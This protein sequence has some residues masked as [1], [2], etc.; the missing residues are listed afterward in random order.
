MKTKTTTKGGAEQYL[1]PASEVVLL[2]PYVPIL[3]GSPN[4]MMDDNSWS[5]DGTEG[6]W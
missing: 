5:Y 3:S 2:A 4:L 1:A 6:E